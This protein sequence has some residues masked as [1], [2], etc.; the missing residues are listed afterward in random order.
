MVFR[1]RGNDE[2]RR[3]HRTW[4]VIPGRFLKKANVVR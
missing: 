4:E 2:S 3:F 1:L